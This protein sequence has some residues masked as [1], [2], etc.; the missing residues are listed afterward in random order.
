MGESPT[1][2]RAS[3]PAGSESCVDQGRPWLRSVDSERAGRAT[4]PRNQA[5]VVA[6]GFETPEGNTGTAVRA[7]RARPTGVGERGTYARVL[8]EPGRSRCLPVTTAKGV[9]VNFLQACGRRAT[10]PWERNKRAQRGTVARA[11]AKRGGTDVGKS[12]RRV[13]PRKRGNQ[14]KGPRGGKHGASSWNRR[15]ERCP[16]HRIWRASQR[17]EDG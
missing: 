2:P 16:E 3:H 8:Q 15:R 7:R 4:E 14:A 5:I 6:D 11:K 13:L 10:R 12:E 17:N 9:A 1:R